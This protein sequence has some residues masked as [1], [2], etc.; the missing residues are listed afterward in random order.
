VHALLAAR[1]DRLA[2]RDKDVLQTA[3]VIGR[4]FDEPTLAAVVEQD[5]PQ[6]REAL[7][8]LKDTEFVYERSLYPVA[9]YLFKHPLTQEVAIASQLQE[10]RRRLHA[11]VARVVEAAHAHDLERQAALLAHH[12]EEAADFAQAVRWHRRAAEWAGLSDPVEGLRHWQKVRTLGHALPDKHSK[13]AC[14]RACRT[15]LA[16][17]SWR[18][19]MSEDDVRAV[20]DEGRALARDLGRPA[21][22]ANLLPGVAAQLGVIGRAEAAL[23][24][25]QEAAALVDDTLGPAEIIAVDVGTSYWGLTAGRIPDAL[26]VLDRMVERTGGDP[27]LGREIVGFSP[28]VW[29][30]GVAAIALA[31]AGRFKEYGPRE[32]RAIRQA[33]EHAL[34]EN[35]GWVLGM[36][37]TAAYLQRATSA[38]AIADMLRSASE[39]VEIADAVG[40]RYSQIA[41]SSNL[42]TAS[43]LSG[44]YAACEER[45]VECLAS[46]RESGTGLD[47]H[48]QMLAMLADARLAG[49]NAEGAIAAAREGISVADAGG[50]WFQSAQAR[51]ALVDA[52]VQTG[53]PDHAIARV[54]DEARELVR[55]S[56]GNSL[57]PRLREAEARLARDDVATLIAGL[58]EAAAMYRAMGAPDP[59][60]RLMRELDA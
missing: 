1:I 46:A 20:L 25:A 33:R 2:E 10:R 54:I 7:Q 16:A 59:A 30:E 5:A 43:F 11:A 17:G 9:E 34:Q 51:A 6:L 50:A 27:Q 55:K 19:G 57:L 41:A 12:W 49:G 3:A 44:D 13:E 21:A 40:S 23:A 8:T 53:A 42:A 4:E 39:A 35:L 56:G 58:H 47:W 32:A 15:I 36:R 45:L 22:V 26:A 24:V 48:G 29:A 28:L 38:A 18:L 14:L 31:Q 37:S 52:L 60:D